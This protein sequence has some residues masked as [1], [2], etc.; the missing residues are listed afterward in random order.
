MIGILPTPVNL[1]FRFE[2]TQDKKLPKA[3]AR[4]D[5]CLKLE[6]TE[7]KQAGKKLRKRGVC[8]SRRSGLWVQRSISDG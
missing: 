4:R 5:R 7:T 3:V 1:K 6:V 2:L 8:E